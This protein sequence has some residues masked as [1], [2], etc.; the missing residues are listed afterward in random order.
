MKT[1]I[2]QSNGQ[3][4]LALMDDKLLVDVVMPLQPLVHMAKLPDKKR[5]SFRREDNLFDYRDLKKKS[6]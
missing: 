2:F 4:V 1:Q 6:K 5:R 3:R